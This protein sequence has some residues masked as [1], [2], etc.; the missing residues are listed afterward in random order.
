MLVAI[1]VGGGEE[2]EEETQGLGTCPQHFDLHLSSEL[3]SNS[4]HV[5]AEEPRLREGRLPA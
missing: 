2:E 4:L 5:T 1:T 3:G